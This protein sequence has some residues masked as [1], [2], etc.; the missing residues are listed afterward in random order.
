MVET[1][2]KWTKIFNKTY[3]HDVEIEGSRMDLANYGMEGMESAPKYNKVE[4]IKLMNKTIKT[5]LNIQT[6]NK[7]YP[8]PHS[9]EK[10]NAIEKSI[11]AQ[12]SA[13]EILQLT[14][15]TKAG[16]LDYLKFATGK[17]Q[18]SSFGEV[19]TGKQREDLVALVTS[20]EQWEKSGEY[21]L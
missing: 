19:T 3:E 15:E 4:E 20:I 6:T 1:E 10:I 17:V 9:S 8:L 13:K 11:A 16:L 12:K 14:A 21:G 7:E 5:V 2:N 18:D